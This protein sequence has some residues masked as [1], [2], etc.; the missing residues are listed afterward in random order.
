M[1]IV[2]DLDELRGTLARMEDR[3]LR[4]PS[5][6]LSYGR[7]CARFVDD[8]LEERDIL[9]SRCAALTLIKFQEEDGLIGQ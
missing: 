3:Y 5:I 6:R 4:N 2:P 8:L 7:L 9:L 1:A